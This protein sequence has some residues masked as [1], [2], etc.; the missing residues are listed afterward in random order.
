MT[1]SRA[2]Y[3]ADTWAPAQALCEGRALWPGPRSGNPRTWGHG[4][5]RL[6]LS[7]TE[8]PL[9]RSFAHPTAPLMSPRADNRGEESRCIGAIDRGGRA[10]DSGTY[11]CS[12]IGHADCQPDLRS[13]PRGLPLKPSSFSR[14][15]NNF[16]SPDKPTSVTGGDTLFGSGIAA[17]ELASQRTRPPA[18][19]RRPS[20]S[21]RIL[22]RPTKFELIVNLKNANA[23]GLSIPPALPL[24]ADEV[25]E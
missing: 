7:A 18:C 16:V 3:A 25:I 12:C 24:R 5:L 19:N 9:L 20:R 13:A 23:L 11:R 17:P 2:Q 14:L 6:P 22:E 8:A 10:A 21:G 15:T 4:A 1:A